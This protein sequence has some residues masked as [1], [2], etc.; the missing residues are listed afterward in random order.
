[1]RLIHVDIDG[2]RWIVLL[3]DGFTLSTDMYVVLL[4]V[5]LILSVRLLFK[6]NS[7]ADMLC[8]YIHI[9]IGTHKQRDVHVHIYIYRE[10][11][12]HIWRIIHPTRAEDSSATWIGVFFL[13]SLM[14]TSAPRGSH[15]I[16]GIHNNATS[17]LH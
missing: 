1:M 17:K 9:H 7:N 2:Y 12:R 5:L 10:R 13:T 15:D 3:E 8:L 6:N 4:V 11:N 14:L 16:L